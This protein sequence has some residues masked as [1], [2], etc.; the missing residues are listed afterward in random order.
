MHLMGL[1]I[2]MFFRDSQVSFLEDIF[3]PSE[4]PTYLGRNIPQSMEQLQLVKWSHVY[5]CHLCI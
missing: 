1:C 5:P 4:F 3:A 2:S